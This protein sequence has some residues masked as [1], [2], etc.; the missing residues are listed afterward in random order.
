MKR[1]SAI[2]LIGCILLCA[3]RHAAKEA[4][5]SALG[6]AQA[7]G[8]QVVPEEGSWSVYPC[9][10][11]SG[12]EE[13]TQVSGFI[14]AKDR[15]I[16][17]D[18]QIEGKA[19]QFFPYQVLEPGQAYEAEMCVNGMELSTAFTVSDA[20]L[21]EQWIEVALGIE[22]KVYIWQGGRIIKAFSCSG[23]LPESPSLL[24]IYQLQDRGERFYSKRFAEG[25]LY[26]IRIQDQY[27]FHS[28]P[29]DEE[30]RVI[31]EELEKIGEAAS[32]GCIRLYDEDARWLYENLPR[33]TM[34]ILHPA[35][36][37]VFTKNLLESDSGGVYNE[38]R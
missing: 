30:G 18:W 5:V 20:A 27:L 22:Q 16:G 34:V 21:P 2:V 26:W 32:H 6:A 38:T 17:G 28:V 1:L 14:R 31:A 29:R 33:G 3:C 10:V 11:I 35:Q 37:D 12:E 15:K 24:G 4:S 9:I 8:W 7:E 23:G 25:A 36:P 19:A 13:I